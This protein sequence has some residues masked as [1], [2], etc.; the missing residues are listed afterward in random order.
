MVDARIQT[1]EVDIVA[2]RRH[3]AT[4][5]RML[6]DAE[7][8]GL[9][10]E[11]RY[12]LLYDAARNG[13][14]AALRAAGV[15]VTAGNRSHVVTF[16]AARGVFGVAERPTLD[17]IDEVRRIRH[18]IEYDT[19]EISSIEVEEIRPAAHA[20]VRAAAQLVERAAAQHGKK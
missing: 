17:R 4:A 13:V 10:A 15:R 1:V 2:A 12:T 11:A 20:I 8:D 3:V 14:T 16:E 7:V 18:Q 19:R 5:E 9:S 6:T